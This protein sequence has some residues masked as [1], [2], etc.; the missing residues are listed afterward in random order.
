M[1]RSRF[2][3]A[4]L[5]NGPELLP[6][7][8][9]R[10]LLEETAGKILGIAHLHRLLAQIPQDGAVDVGNLLIEIVREIVAS[11]SLDEKLR[12]SQR[13]NSRCDVS[14]DQAQTIS[15]MV[16]EIVMNAIKHAHPTGIPVE[17]SIVCTST[18]DG[19]IL[20]ELDDDGIGL[21]ENFDP[22]RD[23]GLGFRLIRA[24]AHKLGATLRIESDTLGLS[25]RIQFPP[26][27]EQ[28]VQLADR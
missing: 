17:M 9:A 13:L 8:A 20:L 18:A 2:Q 11:L 24:L 15:L 1:K 27:C 23:G 14:V 16:V 4:Q 19:S 28:E 21:P 6:Q 25:F 26:A 10:S 3:I 5:R 12:V 22:A 7:E